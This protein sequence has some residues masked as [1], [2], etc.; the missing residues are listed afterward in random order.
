MKMTFHNPDQISMVA[1]TESDIELLTVL[2]R[3]RNRAF[4]Y[5]RSWQAEPGAP[6]KRVFDLP[7]T[8]ETTVA[9][10]NFTPLWLNGMVK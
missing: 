2:V 6:G 7:P 4:Y 10:V 8:P 9:Q 3:N 5:A 1:E